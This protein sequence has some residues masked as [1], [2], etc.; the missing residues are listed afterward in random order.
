MQKCFQQG[1]VGCALCHFG[2][3]QYTLAECELWFNSRTIF[4]ILSFPFLFF[5]F[6]LINQMYIKIKLVLRQIKSLEVATVLQSLWKQPQVSFSFINNSSCFYKDR[7]SIF[8]N[9]DTE[10]I[11]MTRN[12]AIIPQLFTSHFKIFLD[13]KF[14]TWWQFYYLSWISEYQSW[15]VVLMLIRAKLSCLQ[16]TKVA[17]KYPFDDRLNYQMEIF[18]GH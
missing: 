16:L 11:I 8:R 6:P 3:L 15:A 13:L 4:F 12:L 7:H 2:E 17:G 9:T 5:F 10:T 1:M 18:L 14:R